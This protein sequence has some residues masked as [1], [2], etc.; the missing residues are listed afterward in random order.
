MS[1]APWEVLV[2]GLVSAS[3]EAVADE[4]V[5]PSRKTA[6]PHPDACPYQAQHF[7][8]GNHQSLNR[9]SIST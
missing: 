5:S 8:K 4:A 3:R 6:S 7:L 9:F 1:V 2:Y